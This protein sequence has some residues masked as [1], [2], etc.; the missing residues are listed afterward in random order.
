M[1]VQFMPHLQ[2]LE[3][4]SK[5]SLK[6]NENASCICINCS[7][8]EV[9]T[10]QPVEEQATQ[11]RPLDKIVIESY[12]GFTFAIPLPEILQPNPS[13]IHNKYWKKKDG[14]SDR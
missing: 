1:I 12:A 10:N 14:K 9:I 8:K 7:Q 2:W 3:S 6:Y 5:K 11:A 13:I 4:R